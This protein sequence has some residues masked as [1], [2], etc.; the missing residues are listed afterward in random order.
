MKS[1]SGIIYA[2]NSEKGV[3]WGKFSLVNILQQLSIV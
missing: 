3:I 1:I 2:Q